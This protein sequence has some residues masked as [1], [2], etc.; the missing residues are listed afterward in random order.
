MTEE[1]KAHLFEPFF[2]TKPEHKGTGLGLATVYGIVVQ[3]GGFIEV[4]SREGEG[5]RFQISFPIAKETATARPASGPAGTPTRN[6]ESILFVEDDP[7]IRKLL[8]R[9]LQESGF[10]VEEAPDATHA[11]EIFRAQPFLFQLL[12]TDVVMPDSSGRELADSVRREQPGIRVLF[13]SGYTA[14]ETIEH[15][16]NWNEMNLLQ[17]P[18]SMQELTRRVRETLDRV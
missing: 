8:R 4:T 17:K 11:L 15:G 14:N 9:W 18:F 1:V 16:V 3:S 6:S 2:T 13:I 7:A 10:A 12:L 5:T